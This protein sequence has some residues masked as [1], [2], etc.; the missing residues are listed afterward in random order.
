[1]RFSVIL[2]TTTLSVLCARLQW[3]FILV[4]DSGGGYASVRSLLFCSGER[5]VGD[6][7]VNAGHRRQQTGSNWR[8]PVSLSPPTTGCRWEGKLENRQRA[9][10]KEEARDPAKERRGA[11]E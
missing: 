9:R 8:E 4:K 11:R 5:E 1:M 10:E 6:A 3:K 2:E 7:E